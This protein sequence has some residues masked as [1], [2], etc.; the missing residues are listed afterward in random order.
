MFVKKF[1]NNGIPYLRLVESQRYTNS[2][3]IR[4]VRKKCIYNI[5]PLSRFDDGKPDYVD[6]LKKSFKAGSP[7]ISELQK[8]CDVQP[9]REKYSFSISD[10]SS[11][12]IGHPK[13]YSNVLIERILEELG[14]IT[15]FT[16]YK[17][18]TKYKFDLTGFFRH[19]IYGKI[20]NPASKM[21]TTTQNEDYYTPVVKN[22]YEYNIY[23]TL[24]FIYNYKSNII[25]AINRSLIKSFERS[26]HIIYYD[27]TN[28]YFEIESPDDDQ[29]D[30]AGNIVK[31]GTR[32]NGVCKEERKLPIVQMGLF[33]D[34]I[35]P[36]FIVYSI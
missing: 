29:Y 26:T 34:C 7:I 13:L 6:R 11:F 19:L 28:F 12:C 17:Q 8:F 15:F 9:A 32:K 24:D 35:F 33:M 16:R 30:D 27:V 31:K 36:T 20:L 25:N 21:N 14:L 18:L 10:G 5:G 1:S 4:T 23:D 3:G 2:S 22:L